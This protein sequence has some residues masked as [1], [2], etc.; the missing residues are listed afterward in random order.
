MIHVHIDVDDLW[1]YAAEYGVPARSITESVYTEALPR[2]LELLDEAD[3]RATFF[4]VARDLEK[5]SARAFCNEAVHLGH[6]VANHT[7]SHPV[8]FH[9]L[10]P[11][12]KM[13]E[14]LRADAAISD[15]TGQ[16]PVGFR[17]PG[18]YLDG[19]IVETLAKNGYLY[20]SSILPTFV[21][22]LFKLYI[23][24]RSRRSIDKQFGTSRSPLVS[25]RLRRLTRG[26][27][28]GPWIY[29][30]PISV[31]PI[32]RLPVHSTF[33]FQ[34][35]RTARRAV[36]GELLRRRDAVV[37]FHAVDAAG[38][39]ENETLR[40]RVLPLRLG[41]AQR[42]A[43]IREALSALRGQAN[44]TTRDRLERLDPATVPFSRM[45]RWS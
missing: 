31:L 16:K 6:E 19:T 44:V 4:V 20:D 35:P 15:A 5:P 25:Q 9:R 1:I 40:H 11:E 45:L 3:A 13:A 42:I 29:E 22:P 21:Q 26:T 34:L 17:A 38:S 36:L 28:D 12:E 14:I 37:L 23:T 33:S 10:S 32:L 7:F 8:A 41:E 2:F 30:L 18:Y 24:L 43:A 39:I 27:I